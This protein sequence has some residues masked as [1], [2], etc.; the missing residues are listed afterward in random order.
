MAETQNQNIGPSTLQPDYL[1]AFDKITQ[2]QT[3]ADLLQMQVVLDFSNIDEGLAFE[4]NSFQNQMKAHAEYINDQFMAEFIGILSK[5][6]NFCVLYNAPLKTEVNNVKNAAS[7][8]RAK[9][10]SSRVMSLLANQS[11]DLNQTVKIVASNLSVK[12]YELDETNEYFDTCLQKAIKALTSSATKSLTTIDNLQKEIKK[13]IDDIVEGAN[14]IGAATSELLIGLLTTITDA[15][16]GKPNTPSTNFVAMSV[17]GAADGAAETSQ[18]RA[19]LNSNNAKLATEFQ[20]LAKFNGLVAV[21][22]VTKIQNDMF[23]N[24]VSDSLRAIHKISETWGQTP[25]LP[26]ATG[27]SLEFSNFSKSIDSISNGDDA[28]KLAS[29][30]EFVSDDWLAFKMKLNSFKT[31]LTGI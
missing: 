19:N 7:N 11:G 9:E 14:K 24:S 28:Q 13:N 31:R 26:P 2:L 3:F 22:K 12:K 17:K 8:F 29:I 16:G 15:K 23:T 25:V 20:N 27:I 18:A 30:M 4:I 21:A 6:S 1:F 5:S 10:S